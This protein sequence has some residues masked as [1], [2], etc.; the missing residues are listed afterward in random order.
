MILPEAYRRE[1]KA[2]EQ[3]FSASNPTDVVQFCA[4]FF[5]ARLAAERAS[6]RSFSARNSPRSGTPDA[7][8]ENF[9]PFASYTMSNTF[10]NPFASSN[11]F[12][13][14]SKFEPSSYASSN[15]NSM[16]LIE[17]E[18]PDEMNPHHLSSARSISSIRSRSPFAGFDASDTASIH[19]SAGLPSQ[20]NLG[21]R[22]SVSAESLKPTSDSDDNWTP[23][24]HKKSLEQL[25]RLKQ[26]IQDNF[27]F[28]H[29]DEEQSNQVLGAL[30]EKPIPAKD[31]KVISQGDAG[32]F[33]YV[34]E[35]G[36]FAVYVNSSGSLQP[37]ADGMGVKVAEIGPGGSFGE[38]AL[39]Y[40][41]PRAATI[42]SLEPGCLLW[43]LDRVTFRR[44]LMES[45]FSKRRMYE[46]FLGEVP[47][48]ISLTPYERSKVADALEQEKFS[49]GETIIREGDVGNTFYIVESGEAN[50]LKGDKIVKHYSKGD[51]FGELALLNDAPRAATII[52]HTDTKVVSLGKSAF[53]RLLG[54]VEGIMRRTQYV[55][56]ET[57][58]EELDPLQKH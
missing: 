5:T 39:M 27:L 24:F 45:T 14:S 10:S 11:P 26:S 1:I 20:F 25:T 13:T 35:K 43:A 36:T 31:I 49:A 18:S 6:I 22:T 37:G 42:I 52:A 16:H 50:A 44:I 34:V 3:Q 21:R 8:S 47:L 28:K 40:N 58:V 12:D 57:G 41:A 38:L 2:L 55:G 4:D 32:D 54:P 15:D 7:I 23:P 46:T 19:K 33:F 48:L 56:I 30:V 9:D 51:F 53:Q 29:M 17:E